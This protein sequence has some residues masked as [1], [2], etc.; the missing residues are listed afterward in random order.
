MDNAE[1]F[2][3]CIPYTDMNNPFNDVNL[4]EAFVWKKKLEAQGIGNIS[5]EKAEKLLVIFS[6][7]GN[8]QKLGENLG[9]FK[10]NRPRKIF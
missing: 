5:R 3:E 1:A 10:N 2:P 4:T 9:Q 8:W 7:R 6:L